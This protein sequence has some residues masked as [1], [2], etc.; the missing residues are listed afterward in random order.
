MTDNEQ[1]QFTPPSANEIN[2]VDLLYELIRRKYAVAVIIAVSVLLSVLYTKIFIVPTYTSCSKIYIF[3]SSSDTVT[4]SDF[5]VSYYLAR[6]YSELIVDRTVLGQVI[7]ELGLDM[8][9][10]SLKNSIR[11]E[12]PNNS[13]ILEIYVTTANP[14]KSQ[15]IANKVCEVSKEKIV[16]LMGIDQVNII[17]P[18]Y[19]P[20]EPSNPL[21]TNMLWGL[22]AG[23]AASAIFIVFMYYKN[24]KINNEDD[25]QKY[26]GICTLGVIPYS[27]AK[28]KGSRYASGRTARN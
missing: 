13:R 6:D 12:N 16:E 21:K 18:A 19:L 17:S 1:K 2:I 7:D 8:G 4:S 3:N 28:N 23:I 15:Q 24:D 14:K 27:T 25:V 20:S 22:L 9:Y 26:L 10:G 11:I 5:S